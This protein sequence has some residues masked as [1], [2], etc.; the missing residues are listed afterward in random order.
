METLQT[1][2][3]WSNV[4]HDLK[5]HSCQLRLVCTEKLSVVIERDRN[6]PW[7]KKRSRNAEEP[8]DHQVS[9][10]ENTELVFHTEN[11]KHM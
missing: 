10:A 8:Y 7:L 2:R 3:V 5:N 6:F 9:Q 1:K 4:I 11:S